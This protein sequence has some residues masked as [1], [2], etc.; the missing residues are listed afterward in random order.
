MFVGVKKF[1]FLFSTED[2]MQKLGIYEF[3]FQSMH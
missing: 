3:Q 2:T 1:D